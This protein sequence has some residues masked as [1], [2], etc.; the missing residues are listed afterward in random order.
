MVISVRDQ[1][2]VTS[3]GYERYFEQDGQIYWHIMSPATGHPSDSGLI[4]VTVVGDDGMVCD[5]LSLS[6][7]HIS[8]PTRRA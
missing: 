8:E 5:G 6:L 2:V 4:S 7:I 3:G 1:A